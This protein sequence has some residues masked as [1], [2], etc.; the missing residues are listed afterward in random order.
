[1]SCGPRVCVYVCVGGSVCLSVCVCGRVVPRPPTQPSGIYA[2]LVAVLSPMLVVHCSC[3]S[4]TPFFS[5][6]VSIL[7]KCW[8][9]NENNYRPALAAPTAPFA[10]CTVWL[11]NGH[12]ATRRK[13]PKCWGARRRNEE[14]L[15]GFWSFVIFARAQAESKARGPTPFPTHKWCRQSFWHFNICTYI[16]IARKYKS[17]FRITE[18]MF[19]ITEKKEHL[20]LFL[21]KKK[22][23]K[24]S[25][26]HYNL[27]IWFLKFRY[28]YLYSFHI[29]PFFIYCI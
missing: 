14:A 5:H 29:L 26:L 6:C 2:A 16:Y 4:I 19:Q 18:C 9:L 28:V 23:F 21:I 25:S 24:V 1:M 13:I 3:R 20:H 22:V 17:M 12:M 7:N 15:C 11:A 8:Q 10:C 27:K